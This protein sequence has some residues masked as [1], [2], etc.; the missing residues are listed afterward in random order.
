MLKFLLK[1]INKINIFAGILLNSKHFLNYCI[2]K[3]QYLHINV[4]IDVK[5]N[6]K[7]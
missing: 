5:V 4:N 2:K 1:C 7:I 3:G 6:I